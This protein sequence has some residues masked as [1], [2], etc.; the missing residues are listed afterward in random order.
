MRRNRTPYTALGRACAVLVFAVLL[1]SGPIGCGAAPEPAV[2]PVPQTPEPAV[3]PVPQTPEPAVTPVPQTPEPEAQAICGVYEKKLE[4]PVLDATSYLLELFETDGTLYFRLIWVYPYG[5]A[6]H[7]VYSAALEKDDSGFRAVCSEDYVQIT[8]SGSADAV[9]ADFTINGDHDDAFSGRYL[10]AEEPV[11]EYPAVPPLETDPLSP[12]G[13]IERHLSDA[14]RTV[15]GLGPDEALT[16]ERC[17]EVTRLEIEDTEITSLQGVEYFTNL[18]SIY[19]S[20]GYISD[21]SPLASVPSLAEINIGHCPVSEIPDLSGLEN[22]TLLWVWDG[23]ITDLSPVAKLARVSDLNFSYNYVASVAPLRTLE[24][25]EHVILNNNPILDWESIADNAA[26]VAA[27]D[28]DIEHAYAVRERAKEILA[29]TI[30]PGMTDLQ[31][32]VAVCVKLH[33]LADTTDP[34]IPYLP[35]EP[36]GYEVL[37]N[38][39]GVCTD[40]SQA[41]TLLMRMAGL[42]TISCS[43]KD[44]MWNM[45]EL[46]GQWYEFDCY[47]DDNRPVEEWNYFNLSHAEMSKDSS[48][49]LINPLRYPL[50]EHTMM[51]LRSLYGE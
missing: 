34:S 45:I 51:T 22:L 16:E 33:E 10:P 18:T 41:A 21:L 7:P 12:D 28:W 40:F 38:G 47:W 1:A 2:T 15:L 11:S 3:T 42:N 36:D 9:T 31:K 37:I 27:L 14:A 32:Q 5:R 25:P 24:N 26:L 17:K 44:H 20:Y 6:I 4:E 19:V 29:G 43:S 8:L 39:R 50:A 49:H 48:H 30:E 13:R 35:M 23:C 46:D